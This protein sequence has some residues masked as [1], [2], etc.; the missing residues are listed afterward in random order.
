[1]MGHL[2]FG[3]VIDVSFTISLRFEAIKNDKNNGALIWMMGIYTAGICNLWRLC[4]HLLH[5]P[6]G[7]Y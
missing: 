1:M 7:N 4:Q 3:N 6:T 5:Y 2:I